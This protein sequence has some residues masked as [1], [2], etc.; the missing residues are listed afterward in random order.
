MVSLEESLRT[1]NYEKYFMITDNVINEDAW[2]FASNTTIIP[3]E[4][5]EKF[6]KQKK[7]IK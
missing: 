7:V 6:L 3:F 2:S 1:I 5:V 4:E